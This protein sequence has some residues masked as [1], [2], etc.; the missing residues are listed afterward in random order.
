MDCPENPEFVS[1]I[2]RRCE[3]RS[4]AVIFLANGFTVPKLNQNVV[5]VGY[6][7]LSKAQLS[8]S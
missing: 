8:R 4:K 6:K 1:P 2:N 5:V 7:G 3:F